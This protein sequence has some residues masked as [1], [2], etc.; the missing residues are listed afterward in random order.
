M[1]NE[2]KGKELPRVIPCEI[3][4]INTIVYS[5]NKDVYN[6]HNIGRFFKGIDGETGRFYV[7]DKP[8]S[9]LVD[10]ADFATIDII[11]DIKFRAF[12]NAP[13]EYKW[14]AID[15]DSI[16]HVFI[17]EP[18]L[19]TRDIHGIGLVDEWSDGSE[20]GGFQVGYFEQYQKYYKDI[21]IERI[22]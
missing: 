10:L 16:G 1:I 21:V 15:E 8:D 2:S 18:K 9:V 19:Y 13:K 4:P 12:I 14:F 3:T 11:S 20:R 7:T 6:D 5:W 17:H 22:G